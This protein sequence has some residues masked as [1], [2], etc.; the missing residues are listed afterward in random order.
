VERCE[1]K[2]DVFHKLIST[3]PKNRL[4]YID[5]CGIDTY[6]YR[7]HAYAPRGMKV[8]GNISGKKFKRTNIVAAKCGG[9]IVAPMKR[10]SLKEGIS[11]TG[12]RPLIFTVLCN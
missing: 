5:E 10:N 4:Y 3:L 9:S 1:V 7:K 12:R 2:R 11:R 8:Y 6:V